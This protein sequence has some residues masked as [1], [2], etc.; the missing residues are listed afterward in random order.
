[1][2][3]QLFLTVIT[4]GFKGCS[5]ASSRHANFTVPYSMGFDILQTKFLFCIPFCNIVH[6]FI[7]EENLIIAIIVSSDKTQTKQ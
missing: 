4:T 1:M 7:L 2:V 5:I 6:F 3:L